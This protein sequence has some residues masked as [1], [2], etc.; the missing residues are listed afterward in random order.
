MRSAIPIAFIFCAALSAAAPRQDLRRQI[1]LRPDDWWPRGTGHVV[2]S[3]PGSREAGY[4]E[5][6]GSFSPGIG[7]FGV[8][9]FVMEKGVLKCTSDTIPIE[10]VRQRFFWTDGAAAPAIA[11]TT[12]YYEASWSHPGPGAWR[13]KLR[14]ASGY[15]LMAVVRGVGPAAGPITSLV[16]RDPR[17][18]VNNRWRISITPPLKDIFMG[19][20]RGWRWTTEGSEYPVRLRDGWA[21]ARIDLGGAAESEVAIEDPT[22]P[23]WFAVEGAAAASTLKL[24]LPDPRFAESLNAQAAHLMMGL[25]DWQPRA[26]DPLNYPY[27]WLRDGAYIVTAL[28]RSGQTG[29]AKRLA[30][31]YAEHDFFGGFGPEGDAPGLS[32]WAI[33]EAA[34]RIG[35]LRFDAWLWPHVRRKAELIVEMATAKE[36][37][38]RA[39]DWPLVPRHATRSDITLVAEAARDGLIIG[40]M[41]HHRPVLFVNAVSY[42][43][44]LSAAAIASRLA[45]PVEAKRWRTQAAA[46]RKA[47]E[48]GFATPE[49][50]NERTYVSGLW[51]TAI[52]SGVRD[53]FAKGLEARWAKRRTPDGGL[54]ERPLWTY[55]EVAEAHQWLMLR[56]PERTW[57]TLEWFWAN[58]TSP[59]L[60]TWWEGEGEENSFGLWDQVR[61]WANPKHV[62]PHYWT[63][64][65]MLLLEIDMLAYQDADGSVVVGAG[66]PAAWLAK[67]M[68]VRRMW[69]AGGIL[70]WTWDGKK[71]SVNTYGRKLRIRPG[72]VFPSGSA[73]L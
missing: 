16:W 43:G 58:Q 61:G 14:P 73:G 55:F 41:D 72:M 8:S 6:G 28:A 70:D 32:L 1:E 35:D 24:D 62:T 67:R 2:L 45:K 18:T 69:V 37:I 9:V 54:R 49:A 10:Q 38:H 56:R 48:R 60:Y 13:L 47:W 65:E 46:L 36:P 20:E 59:G 52:A 53:P 29:A 17:L 5:P 11:T 71:L 30:T 3:L 63:A 57:A 33:G 25:L 44:L 15:S 4:H 22:P 26:G 64:A 12:P 27:P 39:V 66:I 23:H 51:P 42:Q 40:R 34:G 19:D 21:Y 50:N 7:S 68:S 31:F